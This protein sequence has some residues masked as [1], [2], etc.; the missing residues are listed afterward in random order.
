MRIL[1]VAIFCL[2]ASNAFATVDVTVDKSKQEMTVKVDDQIRYRWPVST[3]DR[4]HDTPSGT[5]KAFRMEEDHFSVEF[6]SAPMPHSIFFTQKGHAVHG[7]FD[8][9]H[10]GHAVSHGCVR[11]HP[12]NATL[13]YALVERHGL[14][15]TTVTIADHVQQN[16][17]DFLQFMDFNQRR[18]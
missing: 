8:T 15:K 18:R 6:D 7:S 16:P 14:S 13:L 11:L 9:K 3:G 5:Y 12:D 17:F 1:W 10:L 2:F 4:H